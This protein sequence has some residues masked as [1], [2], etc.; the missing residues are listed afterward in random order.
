M[1][2]FSA[3]F[4]LE[5]ADCLDLCLKGSAKKSCPSLC[6]SLQ[7]LGAPSYPGPLRPGADKLDYEES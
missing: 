1:I 6:R 2:T 5:H 4:F 3:A 7:E